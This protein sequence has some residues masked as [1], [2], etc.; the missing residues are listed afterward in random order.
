[1]IIRQHLGTEVKYLA[2]PYGETNH[3]VIALAEKLGYRGALTVERE[4][5]PSFVN[6]Y[7]VNRSMVYGSF[8][9]EDFS[10]NLKI[11]NKQALQ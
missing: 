4:S 8:D 3:L 6:R 11:F 1:M 2:Y 9:L 10:K 7:R 5:N